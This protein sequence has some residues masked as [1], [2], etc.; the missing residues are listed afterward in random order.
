MHSSH[1][2]ESD[3]FKKIGSPTKTSNKS[4][5]VII[6]GRCVGTRYI[7]DREGER[8]HGLRN[9]P[10]KKS[11]VA[12]LKQKEEQTEVAEP[13]TTETTDWPGRQHP[14]RRV[15]DPSAPSS[16]TSSE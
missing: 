1:N 12:E 9:L 16:C 11:P 13:E 8:P 15:G 6:H 3:V 4:S 7:D 14:V 10:E 5:W 2:P